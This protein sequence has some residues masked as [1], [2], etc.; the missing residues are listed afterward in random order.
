M[1]QKQNND[2]FYLI[3]IIKAPTAPIVTTNVRSIMNIMSTTVN[4][5]LIK[6][7]LASDFDLVAILS[8]GSSKLDPLNC[9][10][11]NSG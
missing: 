2:I 4:S 9:S 5:T 1:S 6:K 7:F 3:R 8:W 10:N 11:T